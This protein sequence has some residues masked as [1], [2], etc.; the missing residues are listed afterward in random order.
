[1]TRCTNGRWQATRHRV[2]AAENPD[3]SKTSIVTFLLPAVDTVVT[4]LTGEDDHV[5]YEPIMVH[6]WE[7][8]FLAELDAIK[9]Q[10]GLGKRLP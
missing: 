2:R 9:Q 10:E 5:G 4:P 8:V 3:S 1:M 6:D 7:S